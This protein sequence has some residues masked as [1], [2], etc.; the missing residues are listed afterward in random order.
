LVLILY[1]K[2]GGFYLKKTFA[3]I[4]AVMLAVSLTACGASK[5]TESETSSVTATNNP[6]ASPAQ[7]KVTI[8]VTNGKGE[9]ASQ[10]EQAAKD[11]MSVNPNITIEAYTGAVGD[12]INIFDKLTK[13]GKTV[14]IAMM[15]P[16]AALDKYKDFG[17]DLTNEK[18]NE[19]TKDGFKNPNG[20]IVGFPFSIEGFGLVYNK[21]V[22][23]KA[24]GGSFDPF[25]INTRD[26]LKA[27]LDK[28]QASGV[29]YPVAYQTEH[30]S[31]SNHFSSQFLN[32]ATDPNTITT[33]LLAGK[34]DLAGNAAWNGYYD[35]MDLLVSKQYNKYGE[36]PLGKYYDDAHVSVG[37]GE[38]AILFNGNWAFDSLKAVAGDTFGFIPV[39]VDNNPENPLNNKIVAGPTNIYMI[40]KDATPAQQEAAKKYLN[41]LVYDKVGQDF[42][43]NKS[44][45]ISAFKNNPFKV[46]NPLGA[47]IADAI[48]QGKT[49]PFSTNYINAGDW[50]SILGPEVQKYIDKK[51]SRADLAKAIETYYKNKK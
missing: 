2:I 17:I 16:N 40:N 37:K 27:L 33:E 34:F 9:I 47:A 50:G 39:P 49:M 1:K 21:K 15:E 32:Q 29:K 45:V 43:V 41:W 28:V 13:S 51:Q 14:T 3:S 18:W 6:A 20:Q 36:R 44:Q 5:S 4:L 10:Y 42:I 8:I 11:F 31:V 26:Q 38:S 19:E 7:E 35:T 48:V 23:E 46:T 25:S 12:S 30:W 22:I 24:A